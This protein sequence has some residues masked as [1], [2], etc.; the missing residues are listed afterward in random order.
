MR[1]VLFCFGL[2]F[3]LFACNSDNKKKDVPANGS[4][5]Q[6]L[7]ALESEMIDFFQS[8][9]EK[10]YGDRYAVGLFVKGMEKYHFNYVLEVDKERL[11]EINRKLYGDDWLYSYFLDKRALDVSGS[12]RQQM[13]NSAQVELTPLALNLFP[14]DGFSYYQKELKSASHPAMKEMVKIID[15]TGVPIPS[16]IWG[17]LNSDNNR[18]CSD[19]KSDR[20]I[21]MFLTLFCWNY[22]CY[23]ANIDFYTGEDKTE[24]VMGMY[25][26]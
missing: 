7:M 9:L 23:F 17:Q 4:K 12:N 16:L 2:F 19:F 15:A 20:D 5:E 10:N 13:Y 1:N 26:K 25:S 3:L 21:Q 8:T 14:K 6:E 11:K 18:I 22:L 24:V